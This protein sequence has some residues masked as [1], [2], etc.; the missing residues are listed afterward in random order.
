[1]DRIART[2]SYASSVRAFCPGHMV[3][4]HMHRW[5]WVLL[6][7][8]WSHLLRRNHLGSV[9]LDTRQEIEVPK[10]NKPSWQE[11]LLTRSLENV[12]STEINTIQ[13]E[14]KTTR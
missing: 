1:M 10:L 7:L 13:L 9:T 3:P 5:P 14:I 2:R 4:L 11:P 12:G 6:I 8:G